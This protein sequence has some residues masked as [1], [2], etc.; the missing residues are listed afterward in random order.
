[1]RERRWSA[2][3]EWGQGLDYCLT[4]IFFFFFSCQYLA[5]CFYPSVNSVFNCRR[6]SLRC[7]FHQFP[8]LGT[9]GHTQFRK[10]PPD[11]IQ[12]L[13]AQW[14]ALFFTGTV[15]M[16]LFFIYVFV[17]PCFLSSHT[18]CLKFFFV[19]VTHSCF[20]FRTQLHLHGRGAGE[21]EQRRWRR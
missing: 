1:M 11:R 8:G 14:S 13:L 9:S 4:K 6:S 10:L 15:I 12:G 3:K 2:C 19:F 7:D 16:T 21:P 20:F 17:Y 18:D 5:V